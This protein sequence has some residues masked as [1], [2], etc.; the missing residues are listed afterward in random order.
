M[1]SNLFGIRRQF[2]SLSSLFAANSED[3]TAR[4]SVASKASQLKDA[5]LDTPIQNVA[6]ETPVAPLSDI[7]DTSAQSQTNDST[8]LDGDTTSKQLFSLM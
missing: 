5:S 7:G 1:I 2:K 3:S 6:A 8:I 4:T